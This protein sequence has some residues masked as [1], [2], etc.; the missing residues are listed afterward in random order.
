MWHNFFMAYRKTTLAPQEHYH[1]YNRGNN[2]QEVFHSREDYIRFLFYI[3]YLQSPIAF[4][5]ISR[6]TTSFKREGEFSI[7][8]EIQKDIS[9]RRSVALV[10][11]CL[12]PNH[13]HLIVQEISEGGVSKYMQR[14]LNAYSKYANKKYPAKH[15]GHVFQGPFKSVRQKTNEQL[16][17][18][19]AYVHRNPREI[20]IWKGKETHYVWS[21]FQDFV[22]TNRWGNLL[23]RDVLL[24]QFKGKSDYKRFV[25]TSPAKE[26]Y[27]T[28]L[29][30]DSIVFDLK[31]EQR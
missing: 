22:G 8:K 16:L 24:G 18:L 12:M 27:D 15:T 17:Y 9:V 6:Q 31:M 29:F 3:L 23:F 19:S 21:S 25:D 5:A 4:P 28:V 7:S 20:N 11:F 10:S 26:K 13:F 1:L 14:V 2:K 30:D